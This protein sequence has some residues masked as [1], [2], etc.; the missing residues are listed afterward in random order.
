MTEY[1]LAAPLLSVTEEEDETQVNAPMEADP[2][3]SFLG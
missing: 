3:Q 1:Q 2:A